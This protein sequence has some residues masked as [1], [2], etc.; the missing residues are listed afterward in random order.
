[1]SPRLRMAPRT[2]PGRALLLVLAAL[3]SACS[4]LP[5]PQPDPA[6]DGAL[7]EDGLLDLR[8]VV[9]VHTRDSHDSPG[10]VGELVEAAR[11]AGVS[12]VALTEHARPGGP[13]AR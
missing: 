10:D 7:D 11:A 2:E 6:A 13:P 9:H 12:W 3:A 1:M 5:W 8:G 4:T